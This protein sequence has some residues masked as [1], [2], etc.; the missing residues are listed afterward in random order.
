MLSFSFFMFKD[1]VIFDSRSLASKYLINLC[2]RR[3]LMA[4]FV[5]MKHSVVGELQCG[6]AKHRKGRKAQARVLTFFSLPTSSS[7]FKRD[8]RPGW[9]HLCFKDGVDVNLKNVQVEERS[10]SKK[11][12]GKK[13]VT[14]EASYEEVEV[15]SDDV[16]SEAIG[17]N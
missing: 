10:R 15:A 8:A 2:G 17:E 11:E 3:F 4:Y 9:I 5:Y 6:G 16:P 14:E 13:V 7:L 12:K 1:N